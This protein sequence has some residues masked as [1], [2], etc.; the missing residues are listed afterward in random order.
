MICLHFLE[1][2]DCVC[3][4]DHHW[5]P[6]EL[7]TVGFF[8]GKGLQLKVMIDLYPA[9]HNLLPALPAMSLYLDKQFANPILAASL[10]SS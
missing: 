9:L 5:E 3:H 8:F 1:Y 4:C 7:I 6:E 2:D 10:Q